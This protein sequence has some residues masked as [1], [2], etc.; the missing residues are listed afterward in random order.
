M[1]KRCY[2]FPRDQFNYYFPMQ[3]STPTGRT[4]CSYMRLKACPKY[5]CSGM[6]RVSYP[7][8]SAVS[9]MKVSK[10]CAVDAGRGRG[11][12]GQVVAI[13]GKT[14][15]RSFDRAEGLGPIHRVSAWAKRN[16]VSLGQVKTAEKS[17]KITA[18]KRKSRR[19]SSISRQTRRFASYL[20]RLVVTTPQR[21]HLT[22]STL[23][24]AP[25]PNVTSVTRK[26]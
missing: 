18:W 1:G 14:I 17:N 12:P 10:C 16:G 22:F 23:S 24:S 5:R 7:G 11:G 2:P 8:R 15:R 13:G 3:S 6:N 20:A 19:T 4:R 25:K 9:P 26:A 21:L